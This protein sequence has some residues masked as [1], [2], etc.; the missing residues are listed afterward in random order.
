MANGKIAKTRRDADDRYEPGYD[1]PWAVLRRELR[2][3]KWMLIV[4]F[5]IYT[6]FLLVCLYIV[7]ATYFQ[8]TAG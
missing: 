3:T 8:L 4:G 1:D 2:L 6:I 5:S 7:L